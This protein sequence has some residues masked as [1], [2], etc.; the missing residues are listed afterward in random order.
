MGHI[1]KMLRRVIGNGKNLF[2]RKEVN[3]DEKE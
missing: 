1:Y 3:E 2:W